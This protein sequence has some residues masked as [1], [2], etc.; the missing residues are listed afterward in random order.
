MSELIPLTN[1]MSN[2]IGTVTGFQGGHGIHRNL[3]GLGIR[4]GSKIKIVSHQFM[5]GPVIISCGNTQVAIG[6]GMAKRIMVERAK[7]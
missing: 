1:L 7:I 3:E 2:E 6:F 5:R 4:L